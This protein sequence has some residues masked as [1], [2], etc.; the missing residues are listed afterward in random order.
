M[1]VD[2]KLGGEIEEGGDLIGRMAIEN[3]ALTLTW[4]PAALAALMAETARSNTPCWQTTRSCVLAQPVE[5]DREDE[6]RRC[7]LNR[8]Q[9]LLEQ[10][11]IGAQ[12]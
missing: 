5:M 10:Q 12:R 2:P 7:G 9:L 11:R 1:S 8:S 3:G 4:K 6:I